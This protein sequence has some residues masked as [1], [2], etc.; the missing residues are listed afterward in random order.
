MY[1]M[2]Q[3]Q[4]LDLSYMAPAPADPSLLSSSLQHLTKLDLSFTVSNTTTLTAL[5]ALTA[6]QDLK[7]GR[8]S[9]KAGDLDTVTA[10]FLGAIT[11]LGPSL[12]T[13]ADVDTATAFLERPD[14][15]TKLESLDMSCMGLMKLTQE[16]VQQLLGSL[17]SMPNLHVLKLYGSGFNMCTNLPLL[18]GLTQL[19]SLLFRA[20]HVG[21]AA[22][23]RQM[24]QLQELRELEVWGLKAEPKGIKEQL[25][26]LRPLMPKLIEC[27]VY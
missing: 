19:R 4:S 2:T 8:C 15:Q 14:I 13:A 27:T 6:L 3:L 26:R 10:N 18:T 24:T 1:S 16:Q 5:T 11:G 17:T 12:Q 20:D 23:V 7:L 22:L 21:K 25:S 9:L